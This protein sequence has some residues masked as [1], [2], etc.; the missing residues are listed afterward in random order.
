MVPRFRINV[1]IGWERAPVRS[2]H[3][4]HAHIHTCNVELSQSEEASMATHTVSNTVLLGLLVLG[5]WNTRVWSQQPEPGPEQEPEPRTEPG[6][7][8]RPE[9]GP[10]EEKKEKTTEIEEEKDVLVLHVKNFAR[11]LSENSF[12]LV[13]FCE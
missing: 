7:E 10:V 9:P 1:V 2:E 11:A 4:H 3:T 5:L 6:P 13:E 8:P 12:L